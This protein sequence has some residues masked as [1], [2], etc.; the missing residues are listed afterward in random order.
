MADGLPDSMRDRV[1]AR[2][3]DLL[4]AIREDDDGTAMDVDSWR[5]AMR[6]L[7]GSG[8]VEPPMIGVTHGGNTFLQWAG[9]VDHLRHSVG[10]HV[11]PNGAIVWASTKPMDSGY[12]SVDE[13]DIGE[14][15][16]WVLEL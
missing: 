12:S 8:I 9:G 2:L 6:F 4:Q 16:P 7:I 13:L 5:H 15:A 14:I 11:K 1:I 10:L 3:N